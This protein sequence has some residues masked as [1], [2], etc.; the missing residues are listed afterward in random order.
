MKV[1]V[2]GASGFLGRH[3]LGS[4]ARRGIPTVAIGR[5]P[6]GRGACETVTFDLLADTGLPALFRRI[7]ATHLLHLAWYTEHGK[8]WSSPLNLRWVEASLRLVEAFCESGGKHVLVAGTCA[9]YDW[10]YGWCREEGTPLAPNTLYG[11]AK[12]ALRRLVTA[13]CELHG[14]RC[15]WG[16]VF[17]PYGPGESPSRLL[18]SLVEVFRGTRQP[19]AVNRTALRDFLHVSDVVEAFVTLLLTDATGPVNISSGTPTS[20]EAV[21]REVAHALDADPRPV[22]ELIAPRS[23]ET[24]LLVG[25]NR[26][27]QSLGW[28][29]SLTLSEGIANTIRSVQPTEP[30]RRVGI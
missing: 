23:D 7:E 13:T 8:Y 29:P 3:V 20:I 17:L 26:R 21:V 19:F 22:I 12:D 16:R 2:T 5:S 11:I 30:Q 15:V 18:P 25:D 14:T 1:V 27:L 24:P 28:Y 9:E 6:I 4:L 10:S